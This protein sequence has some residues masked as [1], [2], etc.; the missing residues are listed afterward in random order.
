MQRP[1]LKFHTTDAQNQ[2]ITLHF[3]FFNMDYFV[4]QPIVWLHPLYMHIF[5]KPSTFTFTFMHL[6]DTLS[7][8]TYITFKLQF[9]IL[10]ALAFPGNRTHDLAVASAMHHLSYRKTKAKSFSCKAIKQDRC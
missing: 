3:F 10:S 8:A 5:I 7:K 9:Y 6:A 2:V 4:M 1:H